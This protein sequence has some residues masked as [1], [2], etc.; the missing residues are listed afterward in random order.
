MTPE[1]LHQNMAWKFTQIASDARHVHLKLN[2]AELLRANLL[3]WRGRRD[4]AR[5]GEAC[6]SRGDDWRR[7]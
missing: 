5:D 4:R 6:P 2:L 7:H 3:L 1:E